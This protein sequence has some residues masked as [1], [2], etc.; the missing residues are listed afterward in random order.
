M[1]DTLDPYSG[2]TCDWYDAPCNLKSFG[3]WLFDALLWIP[4]KFFEWLTDGLASVVGGISLPFNVSALGGIP[5]GVSWF[6]DLTAAPEGFTI[7]LG[8]LL[9]RFALK[10]IPTLGF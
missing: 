3:E 7:V 9:A 5:A 8:A 2:A 10:L 6:A 4:K 1:T